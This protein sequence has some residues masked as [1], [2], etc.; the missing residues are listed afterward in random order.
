MGSIGPD[1]VVARGEA[2]PGSVTYTCGV[3]HAP[4]AVGVLPDS[5]Q[6]VVLRCVRCRTYN[7]LPD[8]LQAPPP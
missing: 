3:C 2:G 8:P 4:L 1:T 5:L 6:G 7:A